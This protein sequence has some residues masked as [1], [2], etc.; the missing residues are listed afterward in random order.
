MPRNQS[1]VLTVLE[2]K[3]SLEPI[4]REVSDLRDDFETLK[5]IIVGNGTAGI[6]ERVRRNENEIAGH[7]EQIAMIPKLDK[8][9]EKIESQLDF[10]NKIAWFFLTVGGGYILV[11]VIKSIIANL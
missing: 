6:D 1:S 5:K 3:E 4:T 11:E 9:L 2:L 10:Q 8:R 7:R